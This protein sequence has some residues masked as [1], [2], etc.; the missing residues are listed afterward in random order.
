VE[1]NLR[2]N[3]LLL[4]G[5]YHSTSKE[6]G[7]TDPV[8]FEQMGFALD[9]YSSYDKFLIAGDLNVQEGQECLDDFMD[10]FHA[11]NMVKEPTCFKNPENP[12]CIDLY[13]TNSY[14]SFMKTTT[15]STG[16]SDFHKMTVTVMK[17]TFPKS[18]PKMVRYRDFAKYKKEEFGRD[19]K[20]KLECQP[21]LTYGVFENIFL[22][23]LD[24][25]AP[26][27]TMVVRANHK[28][29]VT[30]EMRKAIMLRSQLQNKLFVHGT[31]EYRRAFKH[32]RNYCN[33][34]Y[35][36]ER[37]RFY[38]DLNLSNIN[39]NKKFWKTMK[40]L[41]G[42][43][44]ASRDNIV[45]IEDNNVMSE[46]SEV[47]QTFNKFFG[48]TV[49]ALGITENK[50]LLTNVVGSNGKIADA[51]KMYETHPSIIQI[52]EH[53]TIESK[54][55]F[56]PT[57]IGD[58]QS[59]IK[60]LKEKKA[61]PYMNIPI[62][63][64]KEM[65]H[66]VS[67]PL[68]DIFNEEII[69]KRKFP[70]ELK[71]ADVSPIFKKLE[72]IHK[73]NYRPISVLP[74]VSKI[75]ERIIDKQTNAYMEKYLSPYLCGYRKG[76]SCQHALLVMIEKWKKSLD[77]GGYAGGTL[78]DL[79]K[80][81]DTINH[82]LLIAK[83]HAYGFGTESLEV[84]YDY[85]SDRWQRTKID[86]SFSSWSKILCGM[87]QG[88]VL[89]P[90]FF[91]V[92]IN[93]LFYLFLCTSVCNVADDTTPYACDIDLPNLLHNLE[94]DSA[95]AIFWF[96][97]NYM[98]LNQI[99][100]HFLIAGST[101]QLWTKVG[102]QVIWESSQEKL[103]GMH[104]DKE[105]KFNYHLLDICKKARAKVTALARLAKL[106]PFEKKRILMNSFVESQFSYCPL[107]WMFCSRVLDKK[108]NHIHERALRIVYMDYSSTF[109]DLLKRDGSVTIHQHNIQLVA[110]EMFKV[111][112]NLCPEI[113]KSLFRFN[114]NQ[115]LKKAFFGPNVKTEYRG[116]QSLRYFGPIVW[117]YML[118]KDL[119]AITSIEKFKT[120]VKKWVP[121][122]CPCR[123]CKTYISQIG[124]INVVIE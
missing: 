69:G 119:K 16:L 4:I 45:L 110:I 49:K 20:M 39:D 34:L 8:F 10:E 41:F 86:A 87:P 40:P 80:A 68:K 76:Y 53:V 5:T 21:Q 30:K 1:I 95:S 114:T 59:E 65:V 103:L 71:L 77:E 91:N 97:A 22:K 94:G 2:K 3:K 12:S 73:E 50:L 43:K 72:S 32:Q 121:E 62:R 7:T 64:L 6:Y 117:D 26:Q 109:A 107:V 111:K 67:K 19:L 83:L 63:R 89:G 96:E 81:F 27:K 47:A 70:S 23:T 123:L 9:V 61:F 11:K 106:V 88:S 13:I 29:Y 18:E 112:N 55:S 93:D 15:V 42:N 14:R 57:T 122:N 37:T 54:F 38:C 84:I 25:H 104:I 35:K 102:E 46:D 101:E 116:K 33:R 28:P 115:K 56:S 120:E 74:V 99:K 52:K 31:D 60:C 85:L 100:C 90:K 75:F 105:L 92:Y 36:R 108:I 58:I 66:V 51:I 113:M 24:S 79:S 82:K 98:K 118:P 48:S 17:S 78:M 44:G 124:F